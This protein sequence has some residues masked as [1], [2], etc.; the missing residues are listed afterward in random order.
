MS[1]QSHNIPMY[2]AFG[3][4]GQAGCLVTLFVVGAL[5]LGTVLDG[6]FKSRHIFTLVLVIGSAP[7]SL[8]I[9]LQVTQRLIA[10]MIPPDTTQ[11][12]GNVSTK[13]SDL[14]DPDDQ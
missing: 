7:V 13:N 12:G 2:A 10:R 3:V 11:P 8:F 6:I 9:T 4:A 5:F 14:T 1:K